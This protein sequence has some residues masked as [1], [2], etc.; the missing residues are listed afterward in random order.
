MH[1]GCKLQKDVARFVA[2][3][4]I[5]RENVPR[6]SIGLVGLVQPLVGFLW[7]VRV[8]GEVC[9][10]CE[11]GEPGEREVVLKSGLFGVWDGE[12]EGN[13]NT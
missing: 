3:R 8:L 12:G 10:V 7:P 2:S 1:F 5:T 9:E 13:M 11:K 4:K 6:E